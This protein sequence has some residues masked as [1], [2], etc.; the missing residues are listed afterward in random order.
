MS[1][2][3]EEY[4]TLCANYHCSENGGG[5]KSIRSDG[6]TIIWSPMQARKIFGT[7]F[8]R[9]RTTGMRNALLNKIT[10]R[11]LTLPLEVLQ[12]VKEEL[13]K[14]TGR[15]KSYYCAV[16]DGENW[17]FLDKEELATFFLVDAEDDYTQM[18]LK[19]AQ[20]DLEVVISGEVTT[21]VD[22]KPFVKFDGEGLAVMNPQFLTE[23]PELSGPLL[24]S[25]DNVDE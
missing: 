10:E 9:L 18:F 17:T 25:Y 12:E 15:Y 2:T 8:E 4:L 23:V 1:F 7:D 21:T 20:M 19:A 14:I 13:P 3:A 5:D 16:I 6:S 11:L 24:D 22:L